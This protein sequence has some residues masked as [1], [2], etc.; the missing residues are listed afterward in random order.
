VITRL[1]TAGCAAALAFT[2][3]YCPPRPAPVQHAKVVEPAA[4]A[5]PAK[6]VPSPLAAL[7]D[8]YYWSQLEAEPPRGARLGY[9]QYDGRLP[10]VSPVAIGADEQRLRTTLGEL[11]AVDPAGLSE[12]E[13][14][15]Q[16][17]ALYEIRGDL[18][19]H[20]Q[21][22]PYRNPLYYVNA[23]GLTSY[24]SRPYA[25]VDQRARAVLAIA[26]AAPA[27]LAQA[28]ENLEPNLPRPWIDTAHK[29]FAGMIGFVR[30]DVPKALT[31]LDPALDAELRA[32][33]AGMADA[34]QRFTDALA[35]RLPNATNDYALGEQTFLRMLSE[36]QG[37]TVTL[38]QLER[39]GQDD[40]TRNSTALEAAARAIDP[41]RD[42]R[43]VVA[44]VIADKPAIADMV[45]TASAQAVE[46][47]AFVLERGLV[48]I[49]STHLAEVRE[50]PPYMRF[51]IA[52]LNGSGPFEKK[53]MPTFY[54][55]SPPETSWPEDQQRAYV[56][57]RSSLA[58]ITVHELF[59]G[60]YLHA[61][62]MKK[63]R[64]RVLRTFR[65]YATSEG[66]AHYAEEL[67]ADHGFA[68]SQQAARFRVGQLVMALVRDVR[69]VSAIGL[70]ARGMTVEQSAAL[71]RERALQDAGNAE[72]QAARGTFDPMYGSYTLGKLLIL[73]L[74]ADYRAREEAAGRTF[75]LR[76][77][78]DRF[79][80]YGAPPIPVI[81]QEM[82]GAHA[83]P[84][85]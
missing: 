41:S 35:A 43:T 32:A 34:L 4:P 52:F 62:H 58:S 1:F 2:G 76:D 54:Y 51:N 12:R 57:D 72:Q 15:E 68:P 22:D 11:E 53:R 33:L 61:L 50:T 85:L 69:F 66:W 6:Q 47:R 60:H 23:L 20:S 30:D 46:A 39:I 31:G 84:P 38:E 14:L 13:R 45:A 36:T 19:A 67:M 56:P 27:Y 26:R 42:T 70:H 17:S 3:C 80:S 9:H 8:R 81:R 48:T 59:P 16:Q 49:P 78:H 65:N 40:L 71:F 25:E 21:R 7:L 5:A 18:F 74:R 63:Q 83:G 75:V 44:E 79:L 73:K 24:I 28:D 37:V 64:S 10:D 29:Q 82:L 77:F 55:I